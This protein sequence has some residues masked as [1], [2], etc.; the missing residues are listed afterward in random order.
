VLDLPRDTPEFLFGTSC[1]EEV[2]GCHLD[3]F[4]SRIDQGAK[5]CRKD[6][7]RNSP[8]YYVNPRRFS[9]SFA[10]ARNRRIFF[11]QENARNSLDTRSATSRAAAV[12]SRYLLDLL[13]WTKNDIRATFRLVDSCDSLR[14]NAIRAIF[15]SSL[16]PKVRI[17]KSDAKS[18]PSNATAISNGQ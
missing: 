4:I 6:E 18:L 10:C 16:N 7:N 1:E 3:I 8:T 14:G 11:R 15:I 13:P 17:R 2:R 12:I 5:T 9:L